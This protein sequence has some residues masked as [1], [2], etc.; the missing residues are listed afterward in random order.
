MNKQQIAI[1][2]LNMGGPAKL[3]EVGPFLNRLFT[4]TD[5]MKLPF[6]RFDWP[7]ILFE[8]FEI[9]II[10]LFSISPVNNQ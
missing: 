5:I 7:S 1:L 6:Q 2:M 4:D 9:E 10:Q 8:I 3:E